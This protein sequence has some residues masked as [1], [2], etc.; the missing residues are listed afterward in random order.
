[1]GPKDTSNKQ[2]ANA[3]N[4]SKPVAKDVC[5]CSVPGC[6]W[7]GSAFG[8]KV[9]TGKVHKRV[10][11]CALCGVCESDFASRSG[12]NRHVKSCQAKAGRKTVL[13]LQPRCQPVKVDAVV[14]H[15]SPEQPHSN[16]ISGQSCVM[17]DT[18]STT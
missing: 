12:F 14:D 15:K 10:E 13:N 7:K 4:E 2:Q 16:E 5:V 8:L 3:T 6:G 1:M 17:S 11:E 18:T 9:H